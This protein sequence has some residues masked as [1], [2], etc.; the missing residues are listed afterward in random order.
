MISFTIPKMTCGGCAKSITKIILDIDAKA[1]IDAD[2][3]TKQVQIDSIID[4][5]V[6]R[7]AL[8][9]AGYPADNK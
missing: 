9:T 2:P 4:E 6:F 3:A 8:S 7:T 1:Q 5:R